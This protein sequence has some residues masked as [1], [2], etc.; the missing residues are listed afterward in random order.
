MWSNNVP[1]P[2]YW[3]E[4]AWAHCA[5]VEVVRVQNGIKRK[6]EAVKCTELS[7]KKRKLNDEISDNAGKSE[8]CTDIIDD[9]MSFESKNGSPENVTC[10]ALVP[11]VPL[12]PAPIRVESFFGRDLPHI[13]NLPEIKSTTHDCS[14]RECTALIIYEPPKLP[15]PTT[16]D[17][18]IQAFRASQ[19]KNTNPV[20]LQLEYSPDSRFSSTHT[21]LV[22]GTSKSSSSPSN[23][24]KPQAN[25]EVKISLSMAQPNPSHSKKRCRA[26]ISFP[27]SSLNDNNSFQSTF[28]SARVNELCENLKKHRIV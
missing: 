25:S 3:T 20:M 26:I 12:L 13:S 4:N 9:D 24:P 11:Y 10:T 1:Q 15:L 6:H 14:G 17:S 16:R 21:E 27:N 5:P 8:A 28:S 18:R 22:S 19:A 2:H 23:S 7:L